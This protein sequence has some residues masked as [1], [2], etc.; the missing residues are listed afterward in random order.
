MKTRPQKRA[1][2]R[3]FSVGEA[4]ALGRHCVAVP[5]A[6]WCP[7]ARRPPAG[8]PDAAS[9]RSAAEAGQRFVAHGTRWATT[10]RLSKGSSQQRVTG[11]PTRCRRFAVHGVMTAVHD[12]GYRVLLNDLD[13]VTP[14]G[15]PVR[16]G[17]NVLYRTDLSGR[18]YG[19][20]VT[21]ESWPR[22]TALNSLSSST[23]AGRTSSVG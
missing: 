22:L 3:Q 4:R 12:D 15:Q 7:A 13:L 6:L 2:G 16:W 11:V 14:D 10:T 17:L 21:S 1:K 5:A 23:E 19:P 20:A 9:I 18:V 8:I